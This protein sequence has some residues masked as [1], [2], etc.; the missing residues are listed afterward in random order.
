VLHEAPEEGPGGEGVAHGRV[1][2]LVGGRVEVAEQEKLADEKNDIRE[3]ARRQKVAYRKY[4][5]ALRGYQR[6]HRQLLEA[7]GAESEEELREMAARQEE[8]AQLRERLMAD[9]ASA[10]VFAE[11]YDGIRGLAA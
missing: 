9:R 3:K 10:A 5:R 7:E 2:F 4:Q 11:L 6:R 8:T 1:Q